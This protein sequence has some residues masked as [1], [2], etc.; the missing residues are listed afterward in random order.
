[1]RA[2]EFF[3]EELALAEVSASDVWTPELPMVLDAVHVPLRARRVGVS[4]PVVVVAVSSRHAERQMSE[5]A[6]ALHDEL[7]GKRGCKCS[8]CRMQ[9]RKLEAFASRMKAEGGREALRDAAMDDY[10]ETND[11]V[12]GWL[13]ARA[14]EVSR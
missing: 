11:E 14:E 9:V 6:Q 8:T 4:Q 13:R 12:R 10:V 1:M 3:D 5:A 2:K 7:F